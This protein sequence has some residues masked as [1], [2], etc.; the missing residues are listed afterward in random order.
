MATKMIRS[1]GEKMLDFSIH[2]ILILLAL[3][4]LYPFWYV[5]ILAFN[6]SNVVNYSKIWILPGKFTLENFKVLFVTKVFYN[7]FVISI[8]RTVIGSLTSIICNSSLA[9][10]L[11]HKKLV[12]RKFFMNIVLVTLFFS[13]GLIPLFILLKNLALINTFWVF[14]IPALYGPW[15][16]ILMKT[17]FNSLPASLEE[18]AKIDGANELKIFV[19][20]I[21]PTSMPLLATMLLFA[22]VA[23]WNDWT[24]GQ[25]F[26]LDPDL[27][28]VQTVLMRML[29]QMN[30]VV[31]IQK[32]IS[33]QF[34][35]NPPLIESVKMASIMAVTLPILI[36]YPFLQKYFVQGVMIGAI[37]E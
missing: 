2:T 9:Y 11:T 18:A 20:V 36:V 5:M 22:A 29:T 17:Y 27:F 14:I 8:L 32:S 12:G 34:T 4:T 13:G 24:A 35:R 7:G 26:I 19:T 37:K 23:H 21:L 15:T 16:I 33:E 1:P 30:A 28:P 6:D 25:L 31:M 3:V 10:G